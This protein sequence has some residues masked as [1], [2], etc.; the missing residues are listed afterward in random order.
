MKDKTKHIVLFDGICN[1]CNASIKYIIKHD[2]NDVFRF[3]AIQSS[4]GQ[5]LIKKYGIDTK[6]I[7]SIIYIPPHNKNYYLQSD[8]ALKIASKLRFPINLMSLF[9]I[10]PKFIRNWVYNFIAKNRYKWYGKK[11]RCL[12]PTPQLKA[13][14]L[15]ELNNA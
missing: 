3:S 10:I 12:I 2:K 14:F 9:L 8:A 5:M 1:L 11:D 4:T 15:D 13:K 6:K 7:D